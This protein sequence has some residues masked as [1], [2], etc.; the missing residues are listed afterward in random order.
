MGVVPPV[1]IACGLIGFGIVIYAIWLR[2]DFDYDDWAR[3]FVTEIVIAVAAAHLSLV[4]I[5]GTTGRFRWVE[6]LAYGLNLLAMLLLLSA[7]WDEN[8][9]D[10]FWRFFG[11]VMVLLL[12]VTIARPI[13]NRLQPHRDDTASFQPEPGLAAVFCPRCG[14]RLPT[15]GGASCAACGASFQVLIAS[16]Q[17]PDR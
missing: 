9:D 7:V 12:A 1:G 2:P 10:D 16:E 4:A 14:T 13:L 6:Y 5:T 11:I 15:P 17:P 8:V 3:A